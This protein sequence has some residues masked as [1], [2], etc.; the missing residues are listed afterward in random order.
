MDVTVYEEGYI[1]F[2][3]FYLHFKKP[4]E[5]L[6]IDQVKKLDL[7]FGGLIE[8]IY[9]SNSKCYSIEDLLKD[10][11]IYLDIGGFDDKGN[12]LFAIPDKF[13]GYQITRYFFLDTGEESLPSEFNIYGG[14]EVYPDFNGE[15]VYSGLSF[16]ADN[17]KKMKKERNSWPYKENE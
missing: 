6:T 9:F 8:K 15:F 16:T 4:F 12:Y 7:I 11:S 3:E 1:S 10:Y 2:N 17:L 14:M 13:K 5:N